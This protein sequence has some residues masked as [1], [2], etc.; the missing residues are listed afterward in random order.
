MSRT[1]LVGVGG[2]GTAVASHLQR[3]LGY[4]TLSVN[5]DHNAL[6]GASSDRRL[7]IGQFICRGESARVPARGKR[8][9]QESVCE[10]KAAIG[11]YQSLI[12]VAGLG[13]GTG[14]G[15]M[16][17]LIE[18][19]REL[20]IDVV[21]VVV[22]PFCFEARRRR[23]A[24]QVLDNLARQKFPVIVR[25]LE[26]YSNHEGANESSLLEIFTVVARSIAATVNDRG[27]P[28]SIEA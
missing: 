4:E 17:V 20:D 18:I 21:P 27:H 8:A 19:A 13:G 1:L 7:L 14:S 16:P 26:Q 9:A 25:D 28:Q 22:L 11:G 3:Q 6:N 23:I 24:L 2:A 12:I 15:A 5:T 10:L